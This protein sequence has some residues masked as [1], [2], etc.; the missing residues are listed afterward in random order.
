MKKQPL[1]R[2]YLEHRKYLP[3]ILVIVLFSLFAGLFKSVTS[4]LWGRTVDFGV[5]GEIS[6]MIGSAAALVGVI[7]LDCANT[8]L[9]YHIIGKVVEPMFHEIRCDAFDRL[10]R[11]DPAYFSRNFRTGDTATRL[12][13]DIDILNNFTAGSISFFSKLI[14]QGVISL[15][16][17][18]FLS[19]RMAIVQWLI[20]PTSVFLL[21]RISKPIQ[22]AVRQS[23]EGVGSAMNVAAEAFHGNLTVKAF[24]MEHALGKKFD[25]AVDESL[26]S[27][28]R[29]EKINR[30]LTG[31]K[32]LASVLQTMVLFL[33]GSVLV[34]KG[35]VSIGTLTAFLLLNNYVSETLSEMDYILGQWRRTS[36]NAERYFELIE[37]PQE[38]NG[39]EK[40]GW[41]DVP[42]VAENLCF[43]Y[44][45][46]TQ[47]L[48]N[49]NIK[50]EPGKHV[51]IIGESGCGKSTVLR[52]IS[53]FYPPTS[54][55]LKLFGAN[56]EEWNAENLR[57]NITI[58]TQDPVLFDGS[59]YENAL[60]G[61]YRLS[62]TRCERVLKEVDLWDF[63]CSLPKGMDSDIG[64]RGKTLSGGQKQ[65]L[66]I[67][68]AMV[69]TAPLVLLDEPTSALDNQTEQEVQRALDKL[70]VGRSAV[71]VA[72]RLSTV[73]NAD[74]L[75]VMDGGTVCE[76]GTPT[77]LYNKKGKYYEMY[78]KQNNLK[79]GDEQ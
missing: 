9:Q 34:T 38:Q 15:I 73:Q 77:E 33:A 28:M 8:A 37:I 75:Y 66:C 3:K 26:D 5:A 70:L 42:C 76:E 27:K 45:G 14:L 74:Y 16:S 31:V 53:R 56:A 22:K 1:F 13:T 48:N 63:V 39:G 72:H 4:T 6:L 43:S 57:Q 29:S 18:L 61:N 69:K 58:V 71:I 78:C 44:D 11:S 32:Y 10:S 64:E 46:E 19:W 30:K 24:A 49:L 79:G 54:G 59:I 60:Y 65:R 35:F 20:V 17:C 50:I 67:A 41:S 52:M 40:K 62:R 51:A 12:N 21:N 36:A 55:T 47:V 7:L 25:K 68:R 23:Y 2:F